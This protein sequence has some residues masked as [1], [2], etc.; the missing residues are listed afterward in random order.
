[1]VFLHREDIT[2]LGFAPGDHVDL[3]T[4]WDGDDQV[5]RAPSFRIVEYDTP[6]GTAAAYYPETNPL[7]PLDS[8]ALSSNQPA[9]KSV[10]ISLERPDPGRHT[11]SS[12]GQDEMGTDESHKSHPQPTHVS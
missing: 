2:A 8:T 5:R 7:V 10:I 6:R 4:R 11:D 3:V 12:G 1:M 9:S